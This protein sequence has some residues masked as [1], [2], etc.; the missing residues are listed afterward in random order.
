MGAISLQLQSAKLPGSQ[1]DLT[2][3]LDQSD[4]HRAFDKV[5]SELGQQP[6]PGF[7]PGH[8]PPRIIKRRIKPDVL[9]DMFW[10]KAVETFVEPELEKEELKLIGEP[11]FPKFDEIEVSEDQGVAFTLTVTVQ[12]EP[13]LPEYKGLKLHRLQSAVTDEQVAAGLEQLRQAAGKESPVKDRDTVEKG[14]LVSAQ[15]KIT[16]A[17]Q[18]E[19]VNE[20]SQVFEIGSGRYT[21]AID[22]AMIGQKLDETISLEHT[23]PEDHEEA[24][25]AGQQATLSVTIEEI[26]QRIL[27]ELDD[28]FAKSQ[29]EYEGLEDLTAQTRE[30]LEKQATQR[31]RE[32]LENDALAAVVRDTKIEL[33]EKLVEGVAQRGFA[34][35]AQ[36]LEENGMS[37]A[38]FAEIANA[39]PEVLQANERMRAE[40]A[41]KVQFVL[42]AIAQ[43]EGVEVTDEDL[44][45]EI[46]LF[47]VEANA[48]EEYLRQALEVQDE[49]RER[50]QDRAMRRLTLRT[51]I[52]AAETDEVSQEQYDAIKEQEREAAKAKAEAEAQAAAEAA[53]AE[54][55]AA[56]EAA[57]QAEEGAEAPVEEAAAEAPVE[58]APALE[59][60]AVAEAPEAAA[61][62]QEPA[63]E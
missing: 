41:L 42:G 56:A 27:P 20:S 10:M 51:L 48:S 9:R 22:E 61:A 13:E 26:R 40:L 35:F 16:L 5:Y 12:P 58:E 21:P 43:A 39:S 8:V 52:G 62:E 55:T 31:S 53:Q 11:E 1:L 49:F 14:D 50:L 34:Q 24:E 38:E 7:R 44:G 37:V 59:A 25:L 28:E 18:D 23:Y 63:A 36:E 54:A 2:F 30:R 47:A 15:L 3:E 45:E 32:A 4:V 46:G 6:M 17:G 33:P 57:A 29:G 60:E 19:P